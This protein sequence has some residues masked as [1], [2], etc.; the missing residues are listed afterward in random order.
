MRL[1]SNER[2]RGEGSVMASGGGRFAADE[3][4][5]RCCACHERGGFGEVVVV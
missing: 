4:V 2:V 1:R 3:G 5:V